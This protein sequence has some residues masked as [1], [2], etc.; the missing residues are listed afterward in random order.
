MRTVAYHFAGR[1]LVDRPIAAFDFDSTLREYK[2]KGPPESLTVR[3]LTHLA[4]RFNI[5]IFSNQ[6]GK[7]EKLDEL[8]A[9]ARQVDGV[10]YYAATAHDHYRKP[11]TGMWRTYLEHMAEHKYELTGRLRAGSFFCGDAAGRPGDIAASDAAFAL[12]C[13]LRFY[14]PEKFFGHVLYAKPSKSP[15]NVLAGYSDEDIKALTTPER[16]RSVERVEM[17]L[18]KE[19]RQICILMVGG[20]GSGKTSLVMKLGKLGYTWVSRETISEE[21]ALK[22]LTRVMAMGSGAIVDGTHPTR[23]A[24]AKVVDIAHAHGARVL[25]VHMTTSPALC[26]HLNAARCEKKRSAEIPIQAIRKFWK[27]FEPPRDDEADAV[28]RLPFALTPDAPKEV[29]VMRYDVKR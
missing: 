2:G 29:T 8:A 4:P 16:D 22:E 15:P 26:R 14:V 10:S 27:D 3:F 24:R 11:H 13:S 20:Q 1:A 28:L 21:K 25:I 18:P 12:N 17:A 23:A 7:K 9:Y 5:V 19:W 6:G